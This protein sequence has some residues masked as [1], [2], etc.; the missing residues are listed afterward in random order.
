MAHRFLSHAYLALCFRLVFGSYG[1]KA[2]VRK[3][4]PRH[5][6]DGWPAVVDQSLESES[7]ADLPTGWDFMTDKLTERPTCTDFRQAFGSNASRVLLDESRHK[8]II[9]HI[10]GKCDGRSGSAPLNLNLFVK[11]KKETVNGEKKRVHFLHTS[12]AGGTFFCACAWANGQ[13]RAKEPDEWSGDMNC[14]YLKEDFPCWLNWEKSQEPTCKKSAK[15]FTSTPSA[16]LSKYI[17]EGIDVEGNENYLPDFGLSNKFSNVVLLRPPLER[18]LSHSFEVGVQAKIAQDRI[19]TK[20]GIQAK[21][22]TVVDP[23]SVVLSRSIDGYVQHFGMLADNYFTRTLAGR[24]TF[25]KPVGTLN[26]SDFQRALHNLHQFDVYLLADATLTSE[27]QSAF[28]WDCSVL[29]STQAVHA[30]FESSF[31]GG[32]PALISAVEAKW[33][34]E[35]LQKLEALNK[36]DQTLYLQGK[37]LAAAKR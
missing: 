19:D 13:N 21:N 27:I 15:L 6:V 37:M 24:E 16:M 11:Q 36:F 3:T 17:E 23:K 7:A 30:S 29:P 25:F 31:P 12:K 8:A 4:L 14:H 22:R 2:V 32:T 9:E 10:L 5:E 33:G 18:I 20:L 28:G 35:G 34:K 1:H 26:E